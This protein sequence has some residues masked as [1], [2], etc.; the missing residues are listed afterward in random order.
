MKEHQHAAVSVDCL[1]E[2]RLV[3]H[4]HVASVRHV[5][6]AGDGG[7]GGGGDD[8]INNRRQRRLTRGYKRSN[9]IT[10]PRKSIISDDLTRSTPAVARETV[11]MLL[12]YYRC[13]RYF[14]FLAI[15]LT[16]VI[17]TLHPRYRR[18]TIFSD[19]QKTS[20]HVSNA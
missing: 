8:V 1:L 6:P 11:R 12:T 13:V 16:V 3:Q 2:I 9:I 10:I 7:G 17:N 15:I 4:P 5:F 14:N 18:L 20:A 19:D